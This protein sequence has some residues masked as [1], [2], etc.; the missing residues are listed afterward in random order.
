MLR[1][2]ECGGHCIGCVA[3]QFVCVVFE[4]TQTNPTTTVLMQQNPKNRVVGE[5]PFED[6]A[7]D[8][9]GKGSLRGRAMNMIVCSYGLMYP[10][11]QATRSETRIKEYNKVVRISEHPRQNEIFGGQRGQ[12]ENSGIRPGTYTGEKVVKWGRKRA[13]LINRSAPRAV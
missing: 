10:N 5:L 6:L 4:A 8:R 13:S 9:L 11:Y 2:G 7:A 12:A 1:G 3:L